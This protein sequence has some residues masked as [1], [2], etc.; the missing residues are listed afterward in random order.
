MSSMS[1]RFDSLVDHISTEVDGIPPMNDSQYATCQRR[2]SLVL[3]WKQ[4]LLVVT[5]LVDS[6]IG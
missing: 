5:V 2:F 4:Q 6:G 1:D 3:A